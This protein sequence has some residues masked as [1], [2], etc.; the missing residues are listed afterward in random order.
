MHKGLRRLGGH[1]HFFFRLYTSFFLKELCMR[2]IL[3]FNVK[4]N[5]RNVFNLMVNS[6][7]NNL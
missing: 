6:R 1:D 4:I 2:L 7:T 5:E 3:N